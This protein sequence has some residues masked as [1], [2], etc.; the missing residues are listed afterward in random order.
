[1]A[2]QLTGA[3][4]Q[5]ALANVQLRLPV[6]VIGGG[7]TAVD[8]ATES[9]AYYTVQVERFFRRYTELVASNGEDAVRSNWTNQDREIADEF[10][11][12][13]NAIREERSKAEA[14]LRPPRI[15]G[16]LQSWGGAT[17]AYRR[18]LIDSP[19]YTHNHEEVA[20][21]LEEGIA[22]SECVSPLS[23]EVD[24]FGA[25]LGLRCARQK[26][27]ADGE[28]VSDGEHRFP[29]RTILIAAGTQP[30]TVLA[31]E[32]SLH[33]ELDGK[34]FKACDE[35]GKFVRPVSTHCKPAQPQVLLS[36]LTDGRFVSFFGDLHP[37]YFGNVVKAMASAKQGYPSISRVLSRQP[38]R[39]DDSAPIFFARLAAD[40][41][42]TVYSVERLTPTVVE[43]V[44]QAPA[45]A[46]NFRPGQFYRMQNFEALPGPTD[47]PRQMEGLALTGARVD[48]HQ[49]LISTI[50][51]ETGGSANLCA[52]LKPG[53]PISF[54]GPTGM[55]TRIESNITVILCGGGLGNAVLFSIGKAYRS[56][57]S[58]VLYFA[59]YKTRADRFKH[60]EIEAAADT[61]VWC[62]EEKPR[63]EPGRPQ[64]RSFTGN[65]IQAI[66]AYASGRLGSQPIRT[67]EADRVIAIGSDR[68]M[69]AVAKARHGPLRPYL[70]PHHCAIGSI[71]S[72]MQCMMKEICGQCL[73]PHCDVATGK[74]GHVFSCF[75]QD[76]LLDQVD[77]DLLNVRLSQNSLLEK[78]SVRWL[79][80]G[81][82]EL[83]PS[84][85]R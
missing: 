13:A 42:A 43:I 79:Q 46:R 50:V 16:L 49:G 40:L 4:K 81:R 2:L 41:L 33:F 11:S 74:K 55:P 51:L 8:T 36:R 18:R 31:R 63:F 78:L 58:K 15:I 77:F 45:A 6:V 73:Q 62:C 23:I 66:E 80:H 28:W 14:E 64:D 7:L 72:P 38:P 69:A 52:N 30:N 82:N 24:Q 34:Y 67:E 35:S 56:V 65:I 17:I 9:L 59:A 47:H 71:N 5:E 29:A 83:H 39:S 19:S 53:E 61:V 48:P 68:M 60:E 12:H 37:S 20:K 26:L 10:L 75:D 76:Q 70:K 44:I 1:M 84:L 3:A 57:G 32:D 85:Q 54:M 27:N 22:I 21:A 25:A